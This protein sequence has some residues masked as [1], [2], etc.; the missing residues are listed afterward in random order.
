MWK[1]YLQVSVCAFI[2][3]VILVLFFYPGEIF[4]YSYPYSYFA[5]RGRYEELND[6]RARYEQE[7]R[8]Y[9]MLSARYEDMLEKREKLLEASGGELDWEFHLPSLLVLLEQNAHYYDLNIWIGSVGGFSSGAGEHD[10]EPGGEPSVE[11]AAGG[12]DDQLAEDSEDGLLPPA[13]GRD[14]D[15]KGVYRLPVVVDGS[16]ESVRD[17]LAFLGGVDFLFVSSAVVEPVSMSEVK[18]SLELEIY[19]FGGVDSSGQDSGRG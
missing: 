3:V 4:G 5:L 8:N 19:S 16:Y 1:T 14:R 2:L 6:L 18:A 9:E 7:Q 15:G 12:A 17:Y 13:G 10:E 11:D